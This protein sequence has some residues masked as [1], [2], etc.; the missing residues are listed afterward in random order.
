MSDPTSPPENNDAREGGPVND[1][2]APPEPP[3]SG[4]PYAAQGTPPPPSDPS[5]PSPYQPYGTPSSPQATPPA[6]GS[7][8]PPPAAYGSTPPPPP[9]PSAYGAPSP[10]PPA[11]GSV[12]PQPGPYGPYSVPPAAGF[13]VAPANNTKAV[14]ALSLG[15]AAIVFA[16]CC[17]LLGIP[18]GIAGAVLGFQAK[19]EIA[20]SNGTQ[21]GAGLAQAGFV[22]GIVG[23]A[24]SVVAII[25]SVVLNIGMSTSNLFSP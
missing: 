12:P 24:F 10:V 2:T 13:P 15:I 8:P 20:A 16:F 17:S 18:L 1:P 4:N 21:G 9:P 25:L 3:A 23:G 6:Y 14:V 7:V 11:Y 5:T 19:A 22:T